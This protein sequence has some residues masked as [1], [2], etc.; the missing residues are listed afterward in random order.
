MTKET[1]QGFLRPEHAAFPPIVHVENTNIC[2]IKCIHCPQSDPYR[3]VPGYKPRSMDMETFTRVVDQIGHRRCA[4][5][6]TPDGETLLPRDFRAQLKMIF[7][8]DIHLFAFNT[9]G[10]LLEG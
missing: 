7:D 8:R 1:D 2:N 9:N 5:R 6:M 3:L 4:L 10:L